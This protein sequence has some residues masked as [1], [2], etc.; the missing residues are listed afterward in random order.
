MIGVLVITHEQ[1]GEAYRSLYHHFFGSGSPQHI[2]LIGV[3]PDENPEHVIGRAQEK[4]AE[5]GC[6][7]GILILSDIFGA[8]PCN[9]ARRLIRENETAMLTGLNAPMMV[10][11]AQYAGKSDN[12]AEFVQLVKKAGLDGIMEVPAL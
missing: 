8:T 3:H 10:K 7:D 11:S 6:T 4:I 1:L 5:M 12:L 2:R 9:A